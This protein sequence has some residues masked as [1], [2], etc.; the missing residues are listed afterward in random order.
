MKKC[1][2]FLPNAIT[3]LRIILT[4]LFMV[5]LA[6]RLAQGSAGIPA[7]LYFIFGFI[8]LSDFLDGAVARGLKAESGPGSILD[9]LADSL[10]IF[11]SLIIFDFYGVMPVWFT[12]VVLADFLA[13]L[14][15]SGFLLHIKPDKGRSYFVFDKAGRITAVIFYIIPAAACVAY[16]HPAWKSLLNVMIYLS[17]FTAGVSM[18]GRCVSCFLS[19]KIIKRY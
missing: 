6:G 10:F 15:T 19:L 7:G 14:M 11:S 8:C 13:F 12:A 2:R 4:V 17:V 18:S 9:I 16:A 3:V 1:L 5:I